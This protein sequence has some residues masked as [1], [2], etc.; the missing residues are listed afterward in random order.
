MNPKH[1]NC[2]LHKR[3]IRKNSKFGVIFYSMLAGKS[4]T[5]LLRD[6][7]TYIPWEPLITTVI[8]RVLFPHS[9]CMPKPPV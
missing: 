7:V 1:K 3:N 9:D 6:T 2:L 5:L 4:T 8:T